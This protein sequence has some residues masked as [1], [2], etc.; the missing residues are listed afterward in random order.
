VLATKLADLTGSGKT[1]AGL[2]LTDG[3]LLVFQDAGTNQGWKKVIDRKLNVTAPQAA[4]FGT[5][6]G[7]DK[8]GVVVVEE[9]SISC[10]PIS[11][12]EPDAD[13]TRL[14]GEDLLKMRG[15]AGG[16][17]NGA[18][19]PIDINGDG[20]TD[21]LITAD[22]AAMVLVNRGFGAFLPDTDAGAELTQALAKATPA[23]LSSL[24]ACAVEKRDPKAANDLL[25]INEQGGLFLAGN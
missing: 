3:R 12:D 20:R 18:I 8:P 25:L 21:L 24:R 11:A 10:H 2:L 5:F 7:A 15:F 13:F 22:G 1:E 19:T 14:T 6:T 4:V 16:I 17:K 23:P 9:K